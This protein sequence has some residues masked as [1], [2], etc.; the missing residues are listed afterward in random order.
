M[1]GTHTGGTEKSSFTLM[2]HIKE[3]GNEFFVLSL[4]EMGMLSSQLDEVGIGYIGFPYQGIGGWRSFFKYRNQIKMSSADAVMMTG[5]SLIGMLAL[6]LRLRKKSCLFIHFHHAGVKRKWQWRLIYFLADIIFEKIYF[7]SNFILQEALEIYPRVSNK[8]SYLPN[9]LSSKRLIS[10]TERMACRKKFEFADNDIVIGNA[11]WLIKRK[12]FDIFLTT[13]ARLKERK[14]NIKILIAGEGEEK[15]SLLA[16]SKKLGIEND[17]T[18]LGWVEDLTSFYN[19]I[20]FMLFNSDWD[21]VGLSPLEAIQIGIPAFSSV[22]NGGLKEILTD[23][24]SIFLQDN[25]EIEGLANKIHYAIE[26]KNEIMDLTLKCRD[27]I[28]QLSDPNL[29]AKRVLNGIT[30]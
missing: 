2:T 23:N 27:H 3:Y 26:N 1:Q 6:G 11:G 4:T 10:E 22:V 15:D 7:A 5:H 30:N 12:R 18:W 9:P 17:I 13:C 14:H 25:H 20:D 24:F 8:S 29:I 19:S 28:N 21:S 16:L